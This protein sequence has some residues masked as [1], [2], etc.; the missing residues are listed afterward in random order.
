MFL[1]ISVYC[2]VRN[3]L[4]KSGTFPPSI[5]ELC[6]TKN[7]IYYLL[8]CHSL[9]SET[10]YI[11][12]YILSAIPWR[13]GSFGCIMFMFENSLMCLCLQMC[14]WNVRFYVCLLVFT[15]RLQRP[16]PLVNCVMCTVRAA[17]PGYFTHDHD[18]IAVVRVWRA[19]W[20]LRCLSPPSYKHFHQHY[21]PFSNPEITKFYT[22]CTPKLKLQICVS[23]FRVWAWS[24]EDE[25]P[26]NGMFEIVF[27]LHLYVVMVSCNS[28]VKSW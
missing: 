15:E 10:Q 18:I 27:L 1:V 16:L 22:Y 3:I 26:S 6:L 8:I 17:L 2:N 24:R 11:N 28:D 5:N 7:T 25:S 14:S 19:L 4:A 21:P 12:N 23:V 9:R 13:K 20:I